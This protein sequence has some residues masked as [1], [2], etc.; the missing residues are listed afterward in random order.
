[1]APTDAELIFLGTILAV[2]GLSWLW[3]KIINPAFDP[4]GE[5]P[6]RYC[7]KEEY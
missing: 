4:K 6:Y 1:M 2:I 3:C 5:D 7:P